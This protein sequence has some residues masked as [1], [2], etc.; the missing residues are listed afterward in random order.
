[1]GTF[2]NANGMMFYDIPELTFPELSVVS[3]DRDEESEEWEEP[4]GDD[5]SGDDWGD[6]EWPWPWAA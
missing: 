4:W 5:D 6:D 1:M 2:H 3:Y